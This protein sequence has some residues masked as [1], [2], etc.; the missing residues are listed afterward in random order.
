MEEGRHIRA[1]IALQSIVRQQFE[2]LQPLE[3]K[4]AAESYLHPVE[5]SVSQKG[6]DPE[7]HLKVAVDGAVNPAEELDLHQQ[8]GPTLAEKLPVGGSPH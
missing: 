8:K 7:G 6:T 5:Q 1:G 3:I 2:L 4:G